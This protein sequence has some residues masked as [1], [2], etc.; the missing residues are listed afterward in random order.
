MAITQSPGAIPAE[1]PNF[2]AIS[3]RPGGLTSFSSAMS[4]SS[5]RPT[6]VASSPRSNSR[7]PASRTSI[8]EAPATT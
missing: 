6:I 1:S 8:R 3:G 5:S 7:E 4:V 2:A